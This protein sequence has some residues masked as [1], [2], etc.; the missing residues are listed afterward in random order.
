MNARALPIPLMHAHREEQE[1][2][3]KIL[4]T[5]VRQ[6]IVKF[7]TYSAPAIVLGC[8]QK[9]LLRT[10]ESMRRDDVDIVL[11]RSGGGAVL[12]GPWFISVSVALPKDHM[13]VS[14]GLIN[15][16]QWLGDC[17]KRVLVQLD[18][19]AQLVDPGTQENEEIMNDGACLDWACFGKLS[20][21]EVI[22]NR[23]KIVG[24]A[25][26]RRRNGVLLVGGLLKSKSDWGLLCS[27]LNKSERHIDK[28][29]NITVS[30]EEETGKRI[31]DKEIIRLLSLAISNK[32]KDKAEDK[33]V[34]T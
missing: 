18:V 21:W 33:L 5:E 6:P 25:Q 27:K 31:S 32:L 23:K 29:K 17:F 30:Y 9:S 15:S 20:A 10:T 22:A 3:E 13:L 7:W 14:K 28:L 4:A 24:L 11:R 19:N 8:S 34:L 12:V 26:V 16:F 1:W 2:N